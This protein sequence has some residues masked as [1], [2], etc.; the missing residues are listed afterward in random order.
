TAG[1]GTFGLVYNSDADVRQPIIQGRI[2]RQQSSLTPTSLDVTLTWK[3]VIDQSGDG[4]YFLEDL[5]GEFSV[6]RNYAGLPPNLDDY[7]F[8]AQTPL[9]N[10]SLS[11]VERYGNGVFRWQ[12]VATVNYSDG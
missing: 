9:D 1:D 5:A 8:S 4:N 2:R 7:L 11:L 12:I 6:T 10:E 3:K